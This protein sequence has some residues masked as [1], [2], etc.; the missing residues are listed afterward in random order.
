VDGRAKG[1]R[2]SRNCLMYIR[3]TSCCLG[4]IS[5]TITQGRYQVT[6]HSGLDTENRKDLSTAYQAHL[7]FK[8]LSSIVT[9]FLLTEE[10][11]HLQF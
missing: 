8:A 4:E 5:K 3:K 10:E 1:D 6:Q 7:V 11:R 2:E 9:R